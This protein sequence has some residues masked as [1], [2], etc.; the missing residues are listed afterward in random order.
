MDTSYWQKQT[1]D[2]PLF[3]ELLWSR[4]ENRQFAGKLL[5]VGGNLYG[6]AAAGEAYAAAER[7]GVGVAHVL[8]PDALRKLVGHTL[9]MG[10]F[11]PSTPSGSFSQKAL[12]ELL[13]R[14]AWADGVLVAGDLGRNSETAI[15]LEKFIAA[16]HGQL[17]LT[18]DAVDYITASP[19]TLVG[20]P[21]TTLVLSFAQLQRLAMQAKFSQ[22]FT[23]S[24]DILRLVEALRTFT[25]Q[26]PLSI[27]T[28]HHDSI[29]AASGGNV[30]STK[31]A[32]DLDVWRVRAAAYASVWLV[33]NPSRTYP[34][35]TT[36]VYDMLHA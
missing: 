12:A 16:Y 25:E 29:F 6:F 36:A 23:F 26:H 35:L 28:K 27:V 10:E 15:L 24:M 2:K 4:P 14:A 30:S 7:A 17:I 8:L 22:A 31:L 3:P 18:K 34:A 19:Q 11:T 5:I 21:E 13:P 9:E 33:Q 1:A 20:R 32:A